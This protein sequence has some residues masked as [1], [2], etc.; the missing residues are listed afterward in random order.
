M[1][2]L[3]RE[4]L[5]PAAPAARPVRSTVLVLARQ[6]TTRLLRHPLSIAGLALYALFATGN[7]L[8]PADPIRTFGFID[9]TPT[10]VPGLFAL[11][12]GS[13]LASRDHRARTDELLTPLP[14]RAVERVAAM[15]LA[16]LAPA[17][18]TLLL[19]LALHAV[20]LQQGLY[21]ESP[22]LGHLT[23]GAVTVLGGG[24]FGVMVGTW[25]PTRSAALLALVLM[26]VVN[27]AVAAD[28]WPHHLFALLV[29]WSIYVPE[30]AWVGLRA[31][32]P[33]WHLAYLLGLCGLAACAALLRVAPRRTPVLHASVT[34]LAVAVAGGSGQLP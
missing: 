8:G 24:L 2:V 31:G 18:L 23:Q 9:T 26:V 30:G 1:R 29:E 27:L 7:L 25:T 33:G 11:L 19:V 12:A 14:G 13:L 5:V 32:S 22:G 10:V 4:P 21:V 6:E 17:A 34:F 16:C 20:Q 3:L 15:C 28:G